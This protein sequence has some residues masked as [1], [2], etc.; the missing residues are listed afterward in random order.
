VPYATQADI[1]ARYPGALEQA[2]PRDAAGDLDA[3][4]VGHALAH[5]EGV[6][7]SA[8]LSS[9]LVYHPPY[10]DWIVSAVVD[11]A[12]YRCTPA[13]L[14]PSFDD[15]KTRAQAA[16]ARLRRIGAGDEL[17]PVSPPASDIAGQQFPGVMFSTQPRRGWG[18][19]R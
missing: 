1:D 18:G 7:D 9:G 16:E 13:A 11:I 12:L 5:A 15:R 19:R 8:L 10:P 17:P 14:L 4:A 3:V 6:V 2:G